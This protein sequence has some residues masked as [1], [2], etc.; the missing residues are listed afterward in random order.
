M[1]ALR[2]TKE[3]SPYTALAAGYDAVMAHVDYAAW[4]AYVYAVLQAHH[5]DAEAVL[6]LGCGT[7]SLAL[8][9]QPRGAYRY[10]ATDGSSEMIRIARRKA[11]LDA[12]PVAFDVADFT[13]FRVAEPVD[14]VVLLY[15]GLNYLLE[16]ASVCALLRCAYAAVRP[17]GVFLF[18][19]STPANSINNADFFEDEGSTRG[20]S[21]VRR[22]RYDAASRRHTTTFRLDVGREQF[23]EQHVQRA[24]ALSEIRALVQATAFVEEAAYDGFTLNPATEHAERIHWLLRRP[25]G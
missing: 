16:E 4:A 14:A 24:Y 9:L 12:A 17:G 10:R 6:E 11:G 1:Q 5:P 18:D 2:R 19:Q 13:D 20:F 3:T 15:D 23:H 7:G 8:A 21:Y 25:R 22:S